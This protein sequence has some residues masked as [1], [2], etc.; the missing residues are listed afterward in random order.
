MVEFKICSNPSCCEYTNNF[1]EGN[2]ECIKCMTY[3][4]K[5]RKETKKYPKLN[6]QVFS[7]KFHDH[8]ARAKEKIE[9]ER[10]KRRKQ[11]LDKIFF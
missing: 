9:R 5:I 6:K 8:Q 7:E 4:P 10:E 1:L 3:E 11:R 2:S